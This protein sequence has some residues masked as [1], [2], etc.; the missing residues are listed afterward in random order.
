MRRLAARRWRPPL[1]ALVLQ[2][3]EGL[4]AMALVLQCRAVTLWVASFARVPGT[5]FQRSVHAVTRT[6]V[7]LSLGRSTC[8]LAVFWRGPGRCTGSIAVR[9]CWVAT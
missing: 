7:T 9:V 4:A 6:H 8:G 5:L 1:C 3:P 2:R